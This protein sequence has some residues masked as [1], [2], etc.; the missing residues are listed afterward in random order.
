MVS[1]RIFH[2]KKYYYYADSGLGYFYE[3][4]KVEQLKSISELKNKKN[5]L[6]DFVE[7]KFLQNNQFIVIIEYCA[8]C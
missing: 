5:I 7:Y 1:K 2:R 3:K 6:Q 4:N 8:N